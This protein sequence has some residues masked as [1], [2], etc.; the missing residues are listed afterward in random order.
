MTHRRLV[1]IGALLLVAALATTVQAATSSLGYQLDCSGFESTGGT[2]ALNRDNTGAQSEAF[3]ITA[4]DGGGN[5]IYEPDYDVFFVGTSVTFEAG[6]GDYWT[7]APRFNPLILQVVSPA[8]N[9]LDEQ[10]VAEFVGTCRGLPRFGPI[11]VLDAFTRNAVRRLTGEA[12]VIQAADGE[13]SEVVE[14][15]T[16]PPRPIN[17]PGLPRMMPGYAV[18]NTDNLN[19]RSG[20]SPRYEIVGIVDGGTELVVLGRN[21]DRSWWYVQVGGMRGW[22]NSEFLVLRGDLTGVPE[23]P[24]EG[25]IA[26]PRMYIG[27]TGTPV[28][29]LPQPGSPVLCGIEGNKEYAIV[30]RT[31]RS[32]WFEIEI[33]C[34]GVEDTGWVLAEQGFLRNPANVRIPVSLR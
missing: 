11:N 16:A 30:G 21:K 14:L 31:T 7:N 2:L 19:L 13:T 6:A 18:V 23:V 15:N 25:V 8:G 22:V 34:D 10:V 26:Q 5:I 24:V 33:T 28:L 32:T 20:D 12:F 3:I 1:M 4:I 29:A 27:F 9:G 17:P